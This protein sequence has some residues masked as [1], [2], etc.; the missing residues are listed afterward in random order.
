[1]RLMQTILYLLS[2]DY[3]LDQLC[4]TILVSD[5]MNP[6]D[7][8]SAVLD[9]LLQVHMY[10]IPIMMPMIDFLLVNPVN[11]VVLLE[12]GVLGSLLETPEINELGMVLC[13]ANKV[14]STTVG[15]TSSVHKCGKF[16]D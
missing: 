1:M 2:D 7:S 4:A 12:P 10:E 15:S 8:E 9:S 14:D 6:G 16:H 11:P 3:D 5:F 13:A